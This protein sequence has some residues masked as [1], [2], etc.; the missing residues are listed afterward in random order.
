MSRER[1][2]AITAACN[3]QKAELGFVWGHEP[4]TGE[5]DA[6]DAACLIYEGA[7]LLDL[8]ALRRDIVLPESRVVDIDTPDDWD[9][10]EAL[11]RIARP[12]A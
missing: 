12:V 4:G 10:A 2:E 1:E 8:A 7:V 5:P 3:E 6:G 9:R 11:Y